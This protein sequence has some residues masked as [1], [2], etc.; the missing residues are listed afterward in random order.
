LVVRVLEI[1]RA[2][3]VLFYYNPDRQEI[4][5]QADA[6]RYIF[7]EKKRATS[8]GMAKDVFFLILYPRQRGPFPTGPQ[9]DQIRQWF[10]DV[11][12]GVDM[13]ESTT[14]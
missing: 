6:E 5:T 7:Q 12:Y 10:K 8:N 4:R 14:R 3:G 2:N 13:P 9:L 11:P 1:D